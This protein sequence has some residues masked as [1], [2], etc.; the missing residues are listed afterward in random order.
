LQIKKYNIILIIVGRQY[1]E[2]VLEAGI[3]MVGN[4]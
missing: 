3:A 2:L 4:C 1:G